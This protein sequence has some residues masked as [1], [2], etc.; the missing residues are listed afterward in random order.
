VRV[1]PGLDITTKVRLRGID[2]P[3]LKAHCTDERM[4]AEASRDALSALLARGRIAVID[5]HLD[6]YG[7]RVVAAAAA[8]DTPDIAAAMLAAGHVRRYAG[9]RRES[10]CGPF[11]AGH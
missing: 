11:N 7:G 6:K 3:E 2:A 10:W 8:R 1:W 5:V 9:G 4:R